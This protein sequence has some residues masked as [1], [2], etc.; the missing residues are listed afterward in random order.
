MK[1]YIAAA[2]AVAFA[3][4]G[5]SAFAQSTVTGIQ[6]PP[7]LAAWSS[8]LMNDLNKG[9]R[10]RDEL[11][12]KGPSEGIVA[13]KFNCSESGAPSKVELLK[14][15][16]NREFDFAT[17]R[18]V[19]RIASLHPLPTGLDHDQKYI[20]RMLFANSEEGA[21]QR[22]AQMRRDAD[23]SNAWYMKTGTNTAAIELAPIG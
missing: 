21:K 22:I 4:G 11:G 3:T 12:A 10:V 2:L 17:L 5:A 13:V 1:S 14:S 23:R 7:T 6:A 16:G 8:R 15:S 9:L 18:A 20:V 19:R